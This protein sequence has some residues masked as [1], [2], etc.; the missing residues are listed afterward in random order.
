MTKDNQ[1][2]SPTDEP[3]GKVT[4]VMDPLQAHAMMA[5]TGSFSTNFM[6]NRGTTVAQ[7]Q[8]PSAAPLSQSQSLQPNSTSSTGLPIAD[9]K[10]QQ[11][12]PQQ[13]WFPN[14]VSVTVPT[15]QVP[16]PS[17]N[18]TLSNT[19]LQQST[20]AP[21]PIHSLLQQQ[22]QKASLPLNPDLM[23]AM[24]TIVT[25][26][27][28]QQ[29]IFNPSAISSLF[30]SQKKNSPNTA[31]NFNVNLQAQHQQLPQTIT[32]DSQKQQQQQQQQQPVVQV[33][34][35]LALQQNTNLGFN[36]DVLD[37]MGL[38]AQIGIDSSTSNST[39]LTQPQTQMQ[40]GQT[41]QLSR[42]RNLGETNQ[43]G[44]TKRKFT[45]SAAPAP[46][47]SQSPNTFAM[48]LQP[49][50]VQTSLNLHHQQQHLQ[51][52]P[53][54]EAQ[55]RKQDK[56]EE[57][58]KGE[59][60]ISPNEMTP[61]ERRRYERN[62]R[63]QQ[64]SHR[65][66]QQIKELRNVLTDSKVPFKPNKY[67]ILMSVADYIK[68]LQ[69]QS[70]FLDGEMNKLLNT[71]KKSSEL[72]NSGLTPNMTA[73]EEVIGNDAE[74]LY[75]KGLDYKSIFEQMSVAFA[76]ASL[77]GCIIHCNSKFEA[78]SGYSFAELEKQNLFNLLD[79]SEVEN[80]Y[81]ALGKF[82]RSTGVKNGGSE[83]SSGY[84]SSLIEDPSSSSSGSNFW[85]GKLIKPDVS[86]F[87]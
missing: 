84:S 42:K 35:P 48:N 22:Q 39:A 29:M 54:A 76:V 43:Q 78:I 32:H 37:I 28:G 47:I 67:S 25:G 15:H 52:Q 64:R 16:V 36:P 69:T 61:D 40:H 85:S 68:Q 21:Q 33:T 10:Q 1:D 66:S 86:L 13:S 72:V 45:G 81:K 27:N 8:P 60:C 6:N 3:G 50:E 79:R 63:E 80:A 57:T 62:L 71:I 77:D 65:I 17:D 53:T 56:S 51:Q 55:P 44:P 26:P 82:L 11:Q 30:D 12:L 75:V 31:T 4:E 38:Q 87:P 70:T 58:G 14:L 9:S 19:A 5:A 7:P 74:M 49:P 20:A 24:A 34:Q 2:R 73:N 41:L 18:T 23:Q 59:K 83:T 46:S